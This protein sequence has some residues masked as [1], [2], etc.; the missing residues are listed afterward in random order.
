MPQNSLA[1]EARLLVQLNE[2][3]GHVLRRLGHRR[4]QA[5][6]TLIELLIVVM[7]VGLLASIGFALYVNVQQRGRVG[8]AQADVR[9]LTSAVQLSHAH[10]GQLPT[11]AEGLAILTAISVSPQGLNA[12][13]FVNTVPN[14]PSGG[15]PAWPGAYFYQVD[16]LPGGVASPATSSS[17][18]PATAPS[19]TAPAAARPAPSRRGRGGRRV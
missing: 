18:R 8:K 16:T 6:F 7:I 12:G 3:M 17:A 9:A 1:I 10:M 15:S 19:P 4:D 5:G 14:P 11:N 2:T 13:P